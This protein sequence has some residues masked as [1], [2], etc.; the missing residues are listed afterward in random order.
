MTSTLTAALDWL[1]AL[2]TGPLV[3]VLLT[4]AVAVVGF[5]LLTGRIAVRRGALVI[6]GGFILIGSGQIATALIT[7][8]PQGSVP[9]AAPPVPAVAI[10]RELESTAPPPSRR[11]NPFDP[12]AGNE[13]V[14]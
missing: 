7:A 2:V 5:Q 4:I 6:L 11:G 12:Y 3:T 10:A 8:V 9:V 13:T 14:D 1:V